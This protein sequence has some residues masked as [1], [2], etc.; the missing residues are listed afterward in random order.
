VLVSDKDIKH[1]DMSLGNSFAPVMGEHVKRVLGKTTKGIELLAKQAVQNIWRQVVILFKALVYLSDNAVHS[2]IPGTAEGDQ[3]GFATYFVLLRRY[4]NEAIA[5][6]KSREEGEALFAAAEAQVKLRIGLEFKPSQWHLF[7]EGQK[8]YPWEFL[9]KTLMLYKG[10]YIPHVTLDKAVLQCVCPK[11]NVRGLE[12]LRSWMERARGLAVTSLYC[13][14]ALYQQAKDEFERKL[15]LGITPATTFDGEE[16][17]ESD[18][19]QI[20]GQG[21]QVNFTGQQFPTLAWIRNLYLPAGVT[22]DTDVALSF[23]LEKQRSAADAFEDFFGPEEGSSAWADITPE[24]EKLREPVDFGPAPGGELG[25]RLVAGPEEQGR[26]LPLSAEVKAAYNAERR[27]RRAKLM[28]DREDRHNLYSRGK[29]ARLLS[30]GYDDRDEVVFTMAGLRLAF[31]VAER[32]N[33]AMR[34]LKGEWEEDGDWQ[35]AETYAEELTDAEL[36]R[37]HE[38]HEEKRSRVSMPEHE[39]G[40][41][42]VFEMT[43]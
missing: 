21:V 19:A 5:G 16:T 29:L 31:D 25:V 13:H 34:T 9:G 24:L 4:V 20:L 27:A 28:A 1:C 41:R 30:A 2:G 39:R 12:G 26:L 37:L 42:V 11:K 43:S 7:T 33:D 40:H 3:V 6:V 15:Q 22:A 10:H 14:P 18:L 17:G 23:V 36:D 35:D 32:E 38:R 8:T